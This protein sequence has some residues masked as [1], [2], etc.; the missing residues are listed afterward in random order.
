MHATIRGSQS[1]T[2]CDADYLR[3]FGLSIPSVSVGE[4]W[5]YLI[6]QASAF[7]ASL[8]RLLEPDQPLDVILNRG[9]LSQRILNALGPAPSKEQ[10]FVT[11]LELSNCLSDNRLFVAY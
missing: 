10:L 9:N 3:Q 4:L 5:R 2:V 11:Y 6:K 8:K 7:D 1:V